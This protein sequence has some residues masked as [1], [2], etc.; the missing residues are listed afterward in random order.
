MDIQTRMLIIEGCLELRLA[1]SPELK[2]WLQRTEYKWLS[3]DVINEILAL[4]SQEV[5]R[6]LVILIQD[7]KY[8]SVIVDETSDISVT[9]QVSVCF[10]LVDSDLL[11]HEL[12]TGFYETTKTTAE[13]LY[14]IL[15]D[16]LMRYSL[17]LDDCRSQCY[18]GASNISGHLSGLQSR[19]AA[20]D[21]RAL[22]V[23]CSAH[24]L[25][26]VVQ[27]FFADQQYD[28]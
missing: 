13:T 14:T 15:K 19:V 5:Q 21:P 9:E 20:E 1:D 11:V 25:N 12:F 26:L 16:V 28:T 6:K 27:D 24:S 18:D 7:A 4:I 17:N 23:H 2:S 10:Q 22:Y 8:Y 3:H